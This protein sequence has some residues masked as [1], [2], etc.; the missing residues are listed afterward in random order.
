MKKKKK[1][2]KRRGKKFYLMNP[3]ESDIDLDSEKSDSAAKEEVPIVFDQPN[4]D[5]VILPMAVEKNQSLT[6]FQELHL[7]ENDEKVKALDELE[8]QNKLKQLQNSQFLSQAMGVELSRI[9]DDLDFS[10]DEDFNSKLLE[11]DPEAKRLHE[12]TQVDN[13]EAW[14]NEQNN[15]INIRTFNE[16]DIMGEF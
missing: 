16:N 5:M 2:I 12:K 8:T 4:E 3:L 1:E 7:Q 6:L 11:R 9:S 15:M 10:E 14:L 13:I